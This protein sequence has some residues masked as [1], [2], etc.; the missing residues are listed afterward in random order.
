MNGQMIVE[1]LENDVRHEVR[2]AYYA[3]GLC[4]I[5]YGLGILLASV[6]AL[7]EM[8]AMM[9]LPVL[10]VTCALPAA[11]KR[12]V[13]PRV[14]YVKPGRPTRT[15]LAL[16]AALTALLLAGVLITVLFGRGGQSPLLQGANRAIEWTMS[17]F[18][19]LI[20]LLLGAVMIWNGQELGLRRLIGYG[21][22]M[23]LAGMLCERRALGARLPVR[24]AAPELPGALFFAPLG[25]AMLGIGVALFARFLRTHPV[26]RMGV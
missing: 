25:L 21:G 15:R 6:M 2:R 19:L 5:V 14:G 17:H 18:G 8:S 4:D 1:S 11:K 22:A 23:A 7:G 10:F 26:R 20:G 16:V 3:D 12:W 24:L 13:Q 9:Y